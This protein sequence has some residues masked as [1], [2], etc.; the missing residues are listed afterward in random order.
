MNS[1]SLPIVVIAH[2]RPKSLKRLLTSL[3]LAT[4]P[5]RNITLIISIDYSSSNQDVHRIAKEFKWQYGEKIINCSET[6]LG[7][8]KHVLHCGD[9]SQQ[10]GNVILL[11]DDLY[12]SPCFYHY[13]LQALKFS[14][15]ESYIGGVSLYNHKFNVHKGINFTAIDDGYDNWYFQFASSWGQ[16]WTQTQWREFKEWYGNQGLLIPNSNIPENVTEWSEKSWLKYFIVYLIRSNKYFLYPK[17]SLST[18][19][20]DQGTHAKEDSSA[21]QV[22]LLQY[23]PKQFQFSSLKDSNSIY[24]AYFENIK[25][26]DLLKLSKEEVCLDLNG[27]RSKYN[28]RYILTPKILN[29]EIL[30][31][32]GRRLKP[33]ETNII[34]SIPGSDI[35]LYDSNKT[36]NNKI[37][38]DR[39]QE[40]LYNIKQISY[41]DAFHLFVGLTKLKINRIIK[42]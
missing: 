22:P 20:S 28:K 41:R 19:F 25:L 23:S 39:F 26:Y 3:S 21:Y 35:F 40:I 2:N 27:Y 34:F 17:V 4:Y 36:V 38:K 1:N 8:R 31:S 14:K 10:Y 5:N 16:A 9:Y 11:E 12:V 33:I 37:T 6:N 15:G 18:N 13:T 30:K 42:G 29:Y 32:Y 7:L 24:D